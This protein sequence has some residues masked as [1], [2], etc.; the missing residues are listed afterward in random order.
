M[1]LQKSLRE[2]SGDRGYTAQ[3]ATQF[4]QSKNRH[5]PDDPQRTALRSDASQS[6]RQFLKR[7]VVLEFGDVS[8]MPL[9]VAPTRHR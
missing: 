6:E 1:H 7:L 8:I 9:V 4:L 5:L 3:T 2:H